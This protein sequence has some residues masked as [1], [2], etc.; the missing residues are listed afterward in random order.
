MGRLDCLAKCLAHIGLYLAAVAGSLMSIF[1]ALSAVMRYAVGA[2]FQFTEEQVGL[3]FVAMVF[4]ALPY[5]AFS[6]RQI[7]VTVI[8]DRLPDKL[9]NL[10]RYLASFCTVAFGCIFSILSFDFAALSFELSSMTDMAGIVLY[11]WMALMPIGCGI[12]GII[13]VLGILCRFHNE[14]GSHSS[15]RHRD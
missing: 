1:V 8:T 15:G 12:L 6:G 5:C 4:L 14:S 2:P 7:R 11:P 13:T 10:T 3:L 9:S